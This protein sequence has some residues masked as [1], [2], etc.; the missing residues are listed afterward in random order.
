MK[1]REAHSGVGRKWKSDR[2]K[3]TLNSRYTQLELNI[4]WEN[5][6]L[7]SNGNGRFL[8]RNWS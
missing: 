7:L 6:L 1:I 2:T 3:K 8:I 4:T 5:P